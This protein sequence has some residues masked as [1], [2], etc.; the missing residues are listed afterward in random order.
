[1]ATVGVKGLMPVLCGVYV[2]ADRVFTT[3]QCWVVVPCRGSSSM[4]GKATL[5]AQ[6]SWN[7]RSMIARD[8]TRR[9]RASIFCKVIL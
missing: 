6:R 2:Y 9:Y 7:P 1:M 5:R 4:T 3:S 8:K